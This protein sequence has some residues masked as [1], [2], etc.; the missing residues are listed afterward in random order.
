LLRYGKPAPFELQAEAQLLAQRIGLARCP[1]LWIVPGRISP[2][3][4]ALGGRVRLVLPAELLGRLQPEQQATLLAHELAHAA[5][6]DHW[7]RWL[8][9]L[10]TGLYWWHPIA[11]WARR[12]IQHA[13]E[14]CCDAWVV[15]VLPSAARAYARALLQTVDF[16]DARPALPPVASGIGHVYHLK[17]RLAMIIRDPL[18]PRLPWAMHLGTIVLGLL[19]LPIAPQR[20]EAQ[21]QDEPKASRRSS[22]DSDLRGLDRRLRALEERMDRAL[23]GLETRRGEQEDRAKRATEKATRRSERKVI[24]DGDKQTQEKAKK[25]ADRVKGFKFSIETDGDLDPERLKKLGKEIEEAVKEAVNPERMKQLEKQIEETV[26]KSINP[27]RMKQLEKQIEVLVQKN[28]NPERMEALAKQIE[29]AVNRS[30]NAEQ[31]EKTR[32]VE[33]ARTAERV[34]RPSDAAAAKKPAAPGTSD[35][36]DLERR[37]DRLEERMERLIQA[38]EAS[39]KA[40]QE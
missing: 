8:E 39:K 31:R 4:W 33:R 26:N 20:L 32:Q 18:S 30:L 19:V 34:A 7:V 35:R 2:L 16:L 12:E 27:E 17:R 22:E 9:L 15:W 38:L 25:E 13:E 24:I 11:W 37:L 36:R 3:L 1:E 6:R 40:R 21:S 14:Q 29:S 23:R 28:I 5:R 10:A